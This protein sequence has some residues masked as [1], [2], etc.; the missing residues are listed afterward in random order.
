MESNKSRM[1]PRPIHLD[2]DLVRT[3]KVLALT[4]YCYSNDACDPQ[5]RLFRVCERNLCKGEMGVFK[6]WDDKTLNLGMDVLGGSVSITY[7]NTTDTITKDGET[8]SKT[9]SCQ[10]RR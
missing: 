6:L 2:K 10:N 3:A 1:T 5:C 4:D 7:R 8:R 9:R